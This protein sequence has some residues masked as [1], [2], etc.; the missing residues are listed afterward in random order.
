MLKAF[1]EKNDVPFPLISD[2]NGKL[3]AMYSNRRINY[4]V[5]PEGI[6]QMIQNGIPKNE[7]FIERIRALRK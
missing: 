7:L 6:V 2:K 5:D 4:L 1:A 3:K